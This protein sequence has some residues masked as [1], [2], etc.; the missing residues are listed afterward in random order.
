MPEI[1]E[2][3]E[4]ELVPIPLKNVIPTIPK[5]EYELKELVEDLTRMGC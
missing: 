3:D 1:R 5:K 2:E 4:V